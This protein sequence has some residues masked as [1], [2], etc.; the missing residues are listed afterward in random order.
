MKDITV[1][2]VRPTGKQHLGN[3]LGAV[4]NFVKMQDDYKC[5]FFIADL[6]SLTTHPKAADLKANVR[7][8]LIEYLA[9]GLD[10]EKCTI[11]AQSSV[12]Q[13]SEL[14][15]ILNMLAHMG[16]LQ[17][18]PTFKEKIRGD[19][20][21]NAGLLTYP[22]LMAA[23]ILIHHATKVPVGRDQMQHIEMVR[24]F[25]NRFNHTYGV[26]YF[27][28]PYGFTFGED[29]VSIPSLTGDGK[30]SKSKGEDTVIYLVDTPEQ[31]KK[32]INKIA[33]VTPTEP[34]QEKPTG[35]RTLFE[36][37]KLV[38]S[39]DAI[40]FY[41]EQYNALSIRYGDMKKQ[42]TEDMVRFTG[43]INERV[44]ELES[45]PGYLLRVLEQGGE[46]ARESAKDTLADVQRFI[47]I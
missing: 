19:E 17:K 7:Q 28:E 39:K 46:A 30:M 43:P 26:K 37:M 45:K 42:I 34:G 8:T 33:S 31:I 35:V 18:V 23:D 27:K 32:K 40:A 25:A 20:S 4:S 11:Y 1:S 41:E 21:I 38:S 29:A 22:V 47:G 16:E 10:P 2:G 24:N 15:V 3:Y 6:H 9:C 12:P 44:K 14:Y 36:L 5:F 13:V